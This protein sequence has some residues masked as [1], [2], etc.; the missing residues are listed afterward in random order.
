MA[1][2]DN[3]TVERHVNHCKK[4]KQSSEGQATGH[5]T[6]AGDN[7]CQQE[8]VEPECGNIEG[9]QEE[10]HG[11]VSPAPQPEVMEPEGAM[12]TA[13]SEEMPSAGGQ[14]SPAAVT[15]SEVP[16]ETTEPAVSRSLRPKSILKK[17]ARYRDDNFIH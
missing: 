16:E 4:V 17:P 5:R 1:R 12:S 8:E 9:E 2:N 15:E 14:D 10:G 11:N 7:T 3:H 13:S 6:E